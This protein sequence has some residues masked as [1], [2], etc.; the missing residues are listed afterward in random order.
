MSCVQASSLTAGCAAGRPQ[1][2]S[3]AR[4]AVAVRPPHHAPFSSRGQMP[5]VLKGAPR[6]SQPSAVSCRSKVVMASLLACHGGAHLSPSDKAALEEVAEMIAQPGKGITACDEGPATIGSRFEAVGIENTEENRRAYRQMLF[7]TDGAA[8]YLSAAILDPETLYQRSSTD[9]MLFPEKLSA[10]GIV[11]GVKPHLKVYALPGQSGSTVMQGLDSLAVR[12]REYKEAGCKF[13]KWRSPLEIDVAAGQPSDL[14]IEA[15]MQ[16]LARYALI[17]QD[18]G[19]VPIIEPDISLKGSHDLETAV[20]I[21]IK[22]QA[23]LYKACLDHGVYMEGTVLKSNIVNPGR[24]CPIGYSVEEIGK[25]N[26]DT[27][28][29]CMPVAIR[30]AN[31]LSGGQS[32][33]DASARLNAMNQVKGNFPVNLSFSWSAALQMPLFELCRGK[34]SLEECLDEMS[35]LYLKELKIASAAALGKHTP[36]EGEGDHVPPGVKVEQSVSA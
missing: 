17:C 12:C 25:A 8:D 34:A 36:A 6:S 21:N 11:P 15:N 3:L 33:A 13:A 27:L 23:T 1:T 30:T 16:D 22:V 28:R 19:L 18:E 24:D 32:L 35:E 29:R 9:D 26:I 4:R 10:L 7:E 14:V 5:A 2:R 31:F 20:A